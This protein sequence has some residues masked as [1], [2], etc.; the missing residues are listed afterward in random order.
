MKICVIGTGYVGLVAGT[1]FAEMGNKVICADVIKDKISSLQQNK[2]PIYEPGLGELVEKNVEEKKLSFTTN[3]S[4]A[5]KAAKVI[6]IAVGTPTDEDGTADLQHV[7]A[8]AQSIGENLNEYKIIVNKST[9]PVGTADKVRDKIKT[10]TEHDFDVVSNPEFLKEGSAID[11][12]LK[13]DRVVIGVNTSKA[14]KIMKELYAPFLRNNHPIIFMNIKSAEMSKYAA[15]AMLSTRI[16]FMNEIANLCDKVGANINMVRKAIGSDHRIGDSFLYPGIGYGGSCFPKDVKALIET[17]KE[18]QLNFELMTA[19]EQVNQRQKLILVEKI[20][21][22][23]QE[24]LSG[25]T[26][27]IWGL[28]FKPKTDDVRE[29]PSLTIIEA[30][31]KAGCQIKATD[32]KAIEETKKIFPSEISYFSN[33]YEALNDVNGLIVCTEWSEYRV[34]NFDELK[35]RMKHQVIFDGRNLYQEIVP[36][37]FDYF[38][39]GNNELS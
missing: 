17:A 37:D 10:F 9:V 25:K 36:D 27:A 32:P 29:A 23:F 14:K 38:C 19:V 26:F 8:V 18:N 39:I 3:I 13:P 24:N 5:I 30:L 16:S 1:C 2:I 4:D 15:N 6:F 12:F 7:L 28:A 21:K 35:K 31:L 22:Y 33:R 34:P 11:D 20:K